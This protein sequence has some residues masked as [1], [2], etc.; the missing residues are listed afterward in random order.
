[1][2]MDDEREACNPRP[3]VDSG[4]NPIAVLP[5]GL[6]IEHI[7]SAMIDF[8]DFLGFVNSQLHTK[9]IIRLESML[10]PANF[11]SIVGEFMSSTLPKYCPSIVK[12][13]ITMDTQI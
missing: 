2:S 8:L 10:M 1:M 11:S 5:Y 3:V 12:T 7:R 4:F 9:D 6:Q 13:N